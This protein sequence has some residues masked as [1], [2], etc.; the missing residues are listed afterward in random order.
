M[1][2]LFARLPLSPRPIS[3]QAAAIPVAV[4][5]VSFISIIIIAGPTSAVDHSPLVL[6]AS[7]TIALC[8][9][10]TRGAL[11]RRGMS[12]GLRRSATQVLP[13]IPMLICIAALATTWMLSGIV[14]TMVHY[15][16]T[17]LR[18][19]WFLVTCCAVCAMVS[20]LTGS[21]WS[22]IATIGVAF[23]GIGT[24][25]GFHPGWTAGA[26]ISGAY[27]GD[28]VSPLSDTTII[29]SSTCGVDLFR[30]IRYMAITTIPAMTI[31]L[32]AFGI[33]GFTAD[34]AQLPGTVD[35]LAGLHDMFNITPWT[36]VIPA[37]TLTL[38]ALRLPTLPTLAASAVMGAV[39][40]FIF[41]QHT[42]PTIADTAMR[43]WAGNNA[44]TGVESVDQF[45]S[46]G[47]ILGILPVV[48]LVFSAMIFG[49]I[50]IG[51][52]M[53]G[54]LTA[55]ITRAIRRPV[56]AVATTISTGLTLNATTADQYLSIIICG[57]MYRGLYRRLRLEPR[58]LSRTLEDSISVTSPLIPWSSC[59]VTQAS[60]LGV[61]TL[62]YFPYC[63]FNY[64]TPLM[65]MLMI[66]TGFRIHR[67]ILSPA[68]ATV[69]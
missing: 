61:P 1:T 41:Q 3:W 46:T 20:V 43:I 5:F 33:R 63:I 18:P 45:V 24:A 25:M 56:T 29:A 16:L 2:K 68:R 22:T 50:M 14:P 58:L 64:L 47:G 9:A 48:F 17:M 12:I 36:L 23:I 4:L 39:G 52:G 57:N 66:Y 35:M 6:A 51:T 11:S 13:A 28:K 19:D 26:I 21:S 40:I 8:I 49:A 15:G 62:V 31:A 34:V 42:M 69:K 67:A 53:L 10:A 54:A 55:T 30:H 7:S 37:I 65:S 27:F 38:I 44:A 32:A 60:V 59:G